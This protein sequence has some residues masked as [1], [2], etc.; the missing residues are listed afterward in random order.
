MQI[1]EF[2]PQEGE[3]KGSHGTSV[4]FYWSKYFSACSHSKRGHS[5]LPIC[6][7]TATGVLPRPHQCQS[8][9]IPG[10]KSVTFQPGLNGELCL[11]SYI[12]LH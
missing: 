10:V 9:E 6:I 1:H 5:P 11:F 2:N 4:N 12:P 8:A 3:R 7:K